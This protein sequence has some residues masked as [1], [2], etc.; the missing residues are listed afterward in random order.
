M[1]QPINTP[2]QKYTIYEI[3]CNDPFITDCYVGSTKDFNKRKSVH[4]C[5]SK[6]EQSY[7]YPLYKWVRHFG[8]WDNFVMRP[9][10]QIECENKIDAMIRETHWI[11]AKNSK[12]NSSNKPRNEFE[13]E[14]HIKNNVGVKYYYKNREKELAKYK[15]YYDAHRE[16]LLK[17]KKENYSYHKLKSNNTESI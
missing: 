13:M 2:P 14:Q 12:I 9:I 10:E 17:K 15:R 3:V 4:K 5:R 16:D 6:N 7:T 1:S 8:G 11:N